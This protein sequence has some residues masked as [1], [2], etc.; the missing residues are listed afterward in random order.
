MGSDWSRHKVLVFDEA[1][2][3]LGDAAGRALVQRINRLCRSQNATPILATQALADV[4]ELENLIGA[5]F[6]F[7]VETD[8][9]A[10]RAL[11]LL[12]M[13]ADDQRLSSQLQSFRRGRCFMR[14]YQGRVAPVQIDLVDDQL[15]S[16]LDTTPRRGRAAA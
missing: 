16:Q 11:R 9:E 6:C 14:D 5:Y 8:A 2:M 3:L 10:A 15:L 13:D 4:D 7:G 1:W 12:H